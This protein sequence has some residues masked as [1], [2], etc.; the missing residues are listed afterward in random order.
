MRKYET[1]Y[2]LRPDLEPEKTQELVERF[3][4]VVTTNGGETLEVNEWGK[5][6]LAY[7]IEEYREGY[8]VLMQYNADTDFTSELERLMRISEDVLRYLTLRVEE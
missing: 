2:V 7:E 1:L 6:R 4:G 8:Y 5:R 3:K